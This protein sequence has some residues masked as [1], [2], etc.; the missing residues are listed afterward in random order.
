LEQVTPVQPPFG[1][2]PGLIGEHVPSGAPV[3]VS[4]HD[5]QFPSHA[6]LQQ[7]WAPGSPTQCPIAHSAEELQAWPFTFI[8]TQRW[9][10]V[11]Q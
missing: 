7:I 8:I 6:S 1:S 5:S 4:R 2:A 3:S 10:D 11:S 9:F